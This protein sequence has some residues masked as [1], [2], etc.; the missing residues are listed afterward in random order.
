MED[1]PTEDMIMTEVVPLSYQLS[2][3]SQ[4]NCLKSIIENNYTELNKVA[5]SHTPKAVSRPSAFLRSNYHNQMK[6]FS[7]SV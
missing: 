6:L 4:E 3:F 2:P 1:D 7:A 5:Y